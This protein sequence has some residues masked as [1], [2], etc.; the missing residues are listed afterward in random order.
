M[1]VPNINIDDL[2]IVDAEVGH[3]VEL[4]AC[5]RQSQLRSVL[6]FL[7]SLDPQTI[8]CAEKPRV[9]NPP[10]SAFEIRTLARGE[11]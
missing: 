11:R 5:Y 10:P 6:L 4:L 3:W 7:R 1:T 2:D 9:R 8:K